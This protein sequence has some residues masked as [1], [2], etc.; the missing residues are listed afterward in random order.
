M[1]NTLN[2][3]QFQ[4]NVA[5]KMKEEQ[6]LKD[7]L[8]VKMALIHHK[9]IEEAKEILANYGLKIS[10]N[11]VGYKRCITFKYNFSDN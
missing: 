6:Y 7:I 4:N 2:S 11:P 1:Q 8:H 9:T 3:I 5:L 10:D